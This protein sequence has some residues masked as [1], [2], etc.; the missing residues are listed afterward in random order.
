ME[1]LL[2]TVASVAIVGSL[3]AIGLTIPPAP[4]TLPSTRVL[5]DVEGRVLR[6]NGTNFLLTRSP[7]RDGRVSTSLRIAWS[8]DAPLELEVGSFTSSCEWLSV[9]GSASCGNLEAPRAAG[10][11]TVAL[12]SS[13]VGTIWISYRDGLLDGSELQ[14]Y[15]LTI[16]VSLE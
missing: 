15:R 6:E 12:D 16:T 3:L 8:A 4:P 7:D 9:G 13:Y 1:R 14:V 11:R 10:E 5:L 2:L